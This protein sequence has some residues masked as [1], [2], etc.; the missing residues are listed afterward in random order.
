MNFFEFE[1]KTL[2]SPLTTPA[3]NSMGAE[4]WQL[5]GFSIDNTPGQGA[6]Y[7]YIFQRGRLR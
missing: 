3:L 7:V 6:K 5:V 1:T 4:R 2:N